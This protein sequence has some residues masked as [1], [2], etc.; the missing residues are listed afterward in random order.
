MIASS[1]ADGFRY[2]LIAWARRDEARITAGVGPREIPLNDPL[3]R[4]MDA[5]NA[6]V[7]ETDLL[8]SVAIEGPG[9]RP[10]RSRT[11]RPPGRACHPP[12]I[13]ID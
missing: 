2:K 13:E 5:R 6:L 9:A 4:I 7:F 1:L 3:A 11:G 10:A 12:R 8:G